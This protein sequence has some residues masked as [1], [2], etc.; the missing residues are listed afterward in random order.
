MGNLYFRLQRALFLAV[1]K[2]NAQRDVHLDDFVL[3]LIEEEDIVAA[4]VQVTCL[5]VKEFVLLCHDSDVDIRRGDHLNTVRKTHLEKL[6]TPK[7]T[8]LVASESINMTKKGFESRAW[9]KSSL[10]ILNELFFPFPK[11]S[12]PSEVKSP[13]QQRS[14][15]RNP[16]N[17]I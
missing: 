8:Y 17:W 15:V 12:L 13:T 6:K 16:Q 9:R 2:T 11:K 4:Q 14:W 5:F 1:D 7:S 10:C 3:E